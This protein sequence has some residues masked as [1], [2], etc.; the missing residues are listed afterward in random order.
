[1]ALIALTL[2]TTY[3]ITSQRLQA[4]RS[5]NQQLEQTHRIISLGQDYLGALKDMEIGK[6]GF[7]ISGSETFLEPYVAGASHLQRDMEQLRRLTAGRAEQHALLAR[8]EKL[9]RQKQRIMEQAI[10]LRREQGFDAA[11]AYMLKSGAKEVMDRMRSTMS[12]FLEIEQ[13]ALDAVREQASLQDRKLQTTLFGI[14][15]LLLTIAG[16]MLLLIWSTIVRPIRLLKQGADQLA[17]GQGD[18]RVDLR[19]HHELAELARSFN[20]MAAAINE[21]SQTLKALIDAMVDGVV[22]ANEQGVIE[23]FSPAAERLF[24]YTADE[25]VGNKVDMLMPPPHRQRHAA[26]MQRFL[27]SREPKII[28]SIVEL[29]AQR[30]DGATIP[31]ELAINA[32]DIG[33]TIKFIAAI[34]DIRNRKAAEQA[35]ERQARELELRARYA[36]TLSQAMALFASSR[37][38][39]TMMQDLMALLAER[40]PFP[41]AAFYALDEQGKTLDLVCQRGVAETPRKQIPADAGMIGHAMRE[42]GVLILEKDPGIG[43]ALKAGQDRSQPSAVAIVPIRYGDKA[44]GV[45][46]LASG[47]PTIPLDQSFLE[48]LAA[49][50]GVALDN[51][52]KHLEL[53]TLNERLQRQAEILSSQNRE[54]ERVSRMKSEFLASMSHELRTPLNA[55]IGFSEVLKDQL[56]GRLNERQTDY[57]REIFSSGQHL[58]ALINDILD[59]SKIEAGKMEWL[60]E[61]VDV[62]ALLEQ[63]LSIVRETATEHRIALSLDVAPGLGQCSLD[64][65]KTKQMLYNLLSNAIKFSPDGTSVHLSATRVPRAALAEDME[66]AR[67]APIAPPASEAEHFLELRLEDQGIGI[68][69]ED[70]HKLFEPF[71]QIDSSLARRYEGTGLGLGLVKRLAEIGGGTLGVHSSPGKGSTFVIW[72]P[73]ED[74]RPAHKPIR[75]RA[76]STHAARL[77]LIVEDDMNTARL[78]REQVNH[79]GMHALLAPSAEQAL[80]LLEHDA[81]DAII[82]DIILPG[83]DGWELLARLKKSKHTA[84]IP[85]LIASII[86]DERKGFGFGASSVLQKPVP[87]RDLLRALHDAGLRAR[88]DKEGSVLIIDDDARAVEAM[89]DMLENHG[90]TVFRAL[91]GRQG[92]DLARRCQPDAIL[93]DLMMPGIS[94]FDVIEAL[95]SRKETATIPVIVLTGKIITDEDRR[96]LNG[97]IMQIVE[98]HELDAEALSRQLRA[99]IRD[100]GEKRA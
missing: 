98:K 100:G 53:L 77:V 42:G 81:P 78:M 83:M 74:A 20:D 31:V 38:R 52:Q 84:H 96:R 9:A 23:A 26:Y 34:R 29:E 86:A 97:H 68:A 36:S 57:V 12:R 16:A 15:L 62:R 13:K 41:A 76:S 88:G 67:P 33:P 63:C 99:I 65:R 10:H 87:R 28:G 25:A 5:I 4:V 95:Q 92:I 80:E 19:G 54:L 50:T 2:V 21:R 64:A 46:I 24:G 27:Q 48:Q 35:L 43:M 3:V 60:P 8:I 72:L 30:K 6:R 90:V 18:I 14:D 61:P 49:Q 71:M 7:L 93:L 82:L 40:H 47:K 45:L 85:V 22:V 75:S 11:Q 66:P 39:Q 51:L 69:A 1:M 73:W 56:A 94:G 44:L 89:A 79:A 59:L 58:L 55:I 37:D 70:M 91:D 32:V 17:A